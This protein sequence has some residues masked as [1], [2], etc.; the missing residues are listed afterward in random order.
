MKRKNTLD[1]NA[2]SEA[3][4]AFR[5]LRLHINRLGHAA[6]SYATHA[7]LS[8][9]F[10]KTLQTGM[11]L[12]ST[13]VIREELATKQSRRAKNSGSSGSERELSNYQPIAKLAIRLTVDDP[14][15]AGLDLVPSGIGNKFP[16]VFSS[17][18]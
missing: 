13:Y 18:K 16:Q 6:I 1:D 17:R 11:R 12:R 2:Q 8:T 3:K 10:L 5:R 14:R 15:L 9:Y 7:I 4:V